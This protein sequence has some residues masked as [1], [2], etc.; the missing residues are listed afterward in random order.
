MPES[1]FERR[2]AYIGLTPADGKGGITVTVEPDLDTIRIRQR[3]AVRAVRTGERRFVDTLRLEGC[4]LADV[5]TTRVM[6]AS[7]RTTALGRTTGPSSA[8][9]VPSSAMSSPSSATCSPTTA[10]N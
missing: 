5:A 6:R 3:S 7:V 1:R 2:G 10:T 4:L 9:T 8:A